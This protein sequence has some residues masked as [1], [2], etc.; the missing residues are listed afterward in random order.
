MKKAL[1]AVALLLLAAYLLT[2]VAQVRPG[3]R[4]VVRRFGKVI[5]Q[6]GPGL[7]IGLPYGFDRIDRVPVNLVRQVN[8]GYDPE[9]VDFSV[10]PAGQLLT[11]DQ[12]LVNV[13]VAVE[14]S[15]GEGDAVVD[16]VLQQDRA[17]AALARVV[18]AMLADWVGSHS[19][20]DVLLTGKVGLRGWLPQRVQERIDPYGLGLR[21]LSTNVT[22]L[23]APD[24]V[25][26]DFD[27]VMIAQAG[28]HTRENTARQYAANLKRQAQAEEND[29]RQR[30]D[31]YARG[32]ISLADADAGAFLAR[33]EQYRR[34]RQRNPDI[35]TSIWWSELG[36]LLLSLKANGQVDLLDTRIG[37][38]GIDFMQFSRPRKKSN[39]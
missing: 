20:D 21:I 19:V 29:L 11:G 33:L 16:Y 34:L 7:W 2:G 13:A 1:I 39:E 6:P 23:S 8:I 28:I 36:K 38:D 12:N 5:A 4:A 15:I 35:L 31:A 17:E 10:A 30:A 9:A 25:K 32:R 3:E 22:W 37:A 18:E 24:E 26:S 27:K 14:Y